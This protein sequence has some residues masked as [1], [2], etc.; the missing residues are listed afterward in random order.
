MRYIQSLLEFLLKILKTVAGFIGGVLSVLTNSQSIRKKLILAFL[1]P[2]LLIIALGITSYFTASNT[3]N[4][5]AKDST[6]TTM[7]S[8][9]KYLGLIMHNIESLSFQIFTDQ[10]VQSL[11]MG[12]SLSYENS[13]ILAFN[14]MMRDVQSKL[15]TSQTSDKNI[16]NIYLI[17]DGDK[18]I[19]TS[20]VSTYSKLNTEF[21]KDMEFYKKAVASNGN[22]VWIGEHEDL[23]KET[24]TSSETYSL[25]MVRAIKSM[26]ANTLI[27]VLVIDIK[28]DAI[29]STLD[30]IN[31]GTNSEIHLV[32]PDNRDLSNTPE[33]SEESEENKV[34]D[35]TGE[36]FFQEDITASEQPDGSGNVTYKDSSYLMS[37]AK[38]ENTGYVL[39]GLIPFSTLNAGSNRIFLISALFVVLAVVI[40]LLIGILMSGSMSRT[41]SRLINSAGRAASGDLTASPVSKRKDELGVLTKSIN[42][43]IYSMRNLIEQSMTTSQTVADSAVTVANTSEQVSGVSREISKAIQEIAQG[44]SAQASDAEQGVE[45]ISALAGKINNV[46]DNART[47]DDLTKNTKELTR[48]GLKAIDD[49]DQKAGETTAVTKEILSDIQALD[50]H[51]K[52]IGKIIKVI[53]SIADQTN[54]LA[55]NATIEAARAGEMGRGFAVVADEVRKLAEQSMNATRE[56][57]SI[58]KDTQNQTAMAVEKAS[59]TESILKSQNDA[60]VDTTGILKGIMGAMDELSEKVDQIMAMITDMEDNKEHA[61]S[62]IANI[63]AVSEETAASA[64]EATASTQEQLSSVEELARFAGQLDE[65]AKELSESISRFKL[66]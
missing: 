56:I 23:D 40:A 58:I 19:N 53:G 66:S 16:A 27:G 49:L 31:L 43:M 29:R 48:H 45:K 52:S 12:G 36:A 17:G 38:L 30:S 42:S 64:E 47:I 28:N 37:Y 21:V 13:D 32:S 46:A 50:A 22:P 34:S 7:L 11:L 44:A 25:C 18:S 51:S 41:I 55:L 6:I 62:A 4:N 1:V 15:M 61:I 60:V 10:D 54:L 14:Q 5:N 59:S 63:S 8:S 33:E 2:V 3:V 26:Q 20:S 24:G 39:V 35:I 57:S 65:A 9:G